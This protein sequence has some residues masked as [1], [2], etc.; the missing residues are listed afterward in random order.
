MST[1]EALAHELGVGRLA[2]TYDERFAP[3]VDEFVRNFNERDE[4]GASLCVTLDGATVVDVW[5]GVADPETGRPWERDTVSVVHSC[6]KGGSTSR[7][8]S[9]WSGRSSPAPARRR[10]RS[11]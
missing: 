5:G 6:T 11:G 8:R 10:R 2:G 9:R 4:V 3:V 1:A 7:R